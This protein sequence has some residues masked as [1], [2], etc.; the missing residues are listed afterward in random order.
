AAPARSPVR[1]SLPSPTGRHR[2]GTVAL[3]L[4]D[5]S[6]TDPWVPTHPVREIMAQV[7][8]A[9]RDVA[10]HPVAAWMAPGALAHFT[11]AAGIP[12]DAATW[13]ATHAH[14]GAPVAGRRGGRPVVLFSPGSGGDRSDCT[15]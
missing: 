3:H 13:P 10:G 5:H 15:A 9:A 6:R 8:Y 14:E 1:L 7:W 12:A 11:Q 4:V 2:V